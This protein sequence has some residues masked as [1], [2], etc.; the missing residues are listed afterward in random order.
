MMTP[1]SISCGFARPSARTTGLEVTLETFETDDLGIGENSDF[2]IRLHRRC[3]LIDIGPDVGTLDG[4][5]QFQAHTAKFSLFFDQGRF[6]T[7]SREIEGGI[8]TG[9]STTNTSA[10]LLTGM[11]LPWSGFKC[12]CTGN[13]HTDQILGLF[14][15]EFRIIGV[16]PGILVPDIG[17][18]KE[19]SVQP[20]CFQVSP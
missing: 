6:K 14:R 1:C 4:M 11:T 19:I 15:G 13:S 7:L 8:H 10:C 12:N 18:L 9:N 3:K 16:N 2:V 20:A 5:M 17:H